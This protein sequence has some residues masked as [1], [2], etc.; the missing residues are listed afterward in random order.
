MKRLLLPLLTALVSFSLIGCSPKISCVRK[1][2]F[3][4]REEYDGQN[5]LVEL[6]KSRPGRAW[7]TNILT[8]EK[9]YLLVNDVYRN[10]QRTSEP[11]PKSIDDVKFTR[12]E[13]GAVLYFNE[14]CEPD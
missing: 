5:F 4:T 10:R 14:R 7:I 13:S 3:D 12:L 1:V 8:G 11:F 9:Q 2:S 6:D